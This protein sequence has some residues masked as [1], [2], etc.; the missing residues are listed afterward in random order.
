MNNDNWPPL[1]YEEWKDTLDTLHMWMQIPGKIKLALSPFLN[2]WWNVAFKVTSNGMT[3]GLIPYKNEAFE[4]NFDF[5]HHNLFV[6]KSDGQIKTCSLIP[7][8]VAEFYNEFMSMLNELDI[9][10]SINTMPVEVPDPIA[11]DTDRLHCHYI[12]EYV[13]NWWRILLQSHNILKRFSSP[14]RG[15]SSPVHFFWGSFDL[16]ATR[17]SGKTVTPP[18]NGGRIM[19]FAE[20]EE[21]FSFGFWPG[22]KRFPSPAFYSYLYPAPKDIEKVIIRPSSA[23]YNSALGD[24]IL[25]YDEVRNSSYPDNLIMDFL[26]ST[27][28]QSA[29]LAGWDIR[30]FEGPVP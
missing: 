1:P 20:N 3:T 25:P 28:K 12:K 13:H 24:F 23:Y 22:D 9:S 7:R 18:Q 4:V 6:Q 17:F 11:C 10:V 14:F 5:I 26:Q 19:E 15:K 30:A 16:N 29:E 2:H 27:Y 21:N 8:P